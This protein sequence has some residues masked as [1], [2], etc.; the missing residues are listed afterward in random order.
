MAT[1]SRAE[2]ML[3]VSLVVLSV[4]KLTV[5]PAVPVAM[6]IVLISLPVPRLMSP[7]VPESS[8]RAFVVADLIV[9]APESAM[10]LVVNV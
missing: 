5:S 8:V 6:L 1:L 3:M 7:V 9:S 4:P 10:L 2:P